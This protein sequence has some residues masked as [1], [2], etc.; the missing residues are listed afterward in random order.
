MRDQEEDS[1]TRTDYIVEAYPVAEFKNMKIVSLDPK[2]QFNCEN[3]R[4][5][6]EW[7]DAGEY[8]KFDFIRVPHAKIQ[9]KQIPL[10]TKKT[11]DSKSELNVINWDRPERTYTHGNGMGIQIHGE[12]NDY[13][14]EAIDYSLFVDGKKVSDQIVDYLF[15]PEEPGDYVLEIIAKGRESGV[16]ISKKITYHIVPDENQKKEGTV[17]TWPR[18]I[19]NEPFP[20]DPVKYYLEKNQGVPSQHFVNNDTKGVS[21][22]TGEFLD[23]IRNQLKTGIVKVVAEGFNNF[24]MIKLNDVLKEAQNDFAIDFGECYGYFSTKITD[25]EHVVCIKNAKLIYGQ[26]F[27]DCPNLRKVTVSS[28]GTT[29][30]SLWHFGTFFGRKKASNELYYNIILKNSGKGDLKYYVPESLE[31]IIFNSDDEEVKG[32]FFRK[33]SNVKTLEIRGEK[34]QVPGF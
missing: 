3:D 4:I 25:N 1:S 6:L 29:A 8:R 21:A 34:V 19:T 15:Q 17:S 13:V 32:N 28:M 23:D 9:Y 2:L 11:L 33:F 5:H 31:T 22:A 10:P 16:T 14:A 18:Y 27:L 7:L 24:D 20:I 26:A 30:Y 12:V